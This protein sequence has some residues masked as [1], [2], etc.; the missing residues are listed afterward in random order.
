M[1][2]VNIGDKF[3][4]LTVVSHFKGSQWNCSCSCGGSKVC[5]A[6]NLV[7][8]HNKSCGCLKPAHGMRYHRAYKSWL[9]MKQR[10]TNPENQDYE[11]YGGRG[12]N[13]HE[14]FLKSFPKWLEEM[15]ERPEGRWSVGRKDNN[16]GYTYGNIRWETDAQQARN[17]SKSVKNKSGIVGVRR[18][19]RVI[20][21]KEYTSW[22]AQWANALNKKQQKEFSCNKYGEQE[23]KELAIAYRDKMINDLNSQGFDYAESHGSDK[24]KENYGS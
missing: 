16:I 5:W 7:V 4:E 14:D 9:H 8:D 6:S 23:A 21:G 3:G 11:N 10:C 20:A 19:I 17:H 18:N 13:V 24:T 1:T 12:I 2:E 22:I 15:G